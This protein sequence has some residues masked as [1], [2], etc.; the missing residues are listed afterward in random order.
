MSVLV[1]LFLLVHGMRD[2]H[3]RHEESEEQR[4]VNDPIRTARTM[5][6]HLEV[7]LAIRLT[8]IVLYWFRF[9]LF[10]WNTRPSPALAWFYWFL[11]L[12][13]AWNT[14]PSPALAWFYW[15]LF[16]LFA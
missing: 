4:A 16:L 3:S 6:K 10:A 9:L 12:W 15:F 14:R 8:S 7:S 11:F 2:W 13:F 5:D 1:P